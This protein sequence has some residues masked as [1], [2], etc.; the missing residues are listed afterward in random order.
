MACADVIVTKSGGVTSAECLAA[1][2]PM[3]INSSIPGQE[4]GNAN[5]LVEHGVAMNAMAADNVEYRV[6]IPASSSDQRK[7]MAMNARALARPDAASKV[8]QTVL[9]HLNQTMKNDC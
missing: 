9:S 1:G 8:M 2:L 4:E 7:K 6:R 3:I 5:F